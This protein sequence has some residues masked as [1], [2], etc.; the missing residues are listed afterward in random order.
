[1]PTTI[2]G[3]RM[4]FGPSEIGLSESNLARQNEV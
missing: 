3:R 4:A 1:M 2:N